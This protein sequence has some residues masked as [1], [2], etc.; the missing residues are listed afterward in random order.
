[1]T[2]LDTPGTLDPKAV[3]P[4]PTIK[5]YGLIGGLVSVVYGLIANMTGIAFT[6][7]TLNTVISFVISIAIIVLAVKH[8]RDEDLGKYIP[9][10]RAFMVGFFTLTIAT[11]IALIFNYIYVAFIDPSVVEQGFEASRKM[12]ENFG[13]EEDK[14]EEALEQQRAQYSPLKN[15]LFGLVFAMILNAIFALIVGAIMK[16]TPPEFE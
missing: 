4:W 7:I 6:S 16:K 14:I 3:S 15:S 1:M 2:T 9:F 12:M 13:M 5:R 10:G 8:H 11:V